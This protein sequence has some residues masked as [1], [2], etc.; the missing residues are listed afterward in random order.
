MISAHLDDAV[1]SC[2][3]AVARGGLVVTVFASGPKSID[4]LPLWDQA[5]GCFSPGD[6]VFSVRVQEDDAALALLGATGRRLAFWDVQYRQSPQPRTPRLAN[7]VQRLRR[8]ESDVDATLAESVLAELS[9]LIN[10]SDLREWFA[11]LGICHPDHRILG[12]ILPQ[13]VSQ[14]SGTSWYVYED[15][16]YAAE[17]PQDRDSAR[18]RLEH[19]ALWLEPLPAIVDPDRKLAAINCYRS[20]LVPLGDRVQMAI[21]AEERLYRLASA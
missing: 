6:D 9:A 10:A 8:R 5:S 19:E 3:S 20:Q 17:R 21:V 11:P 4:P 7:A 15:L 2:S 1:L 14:T 18:S 16:P 13:L 12:A